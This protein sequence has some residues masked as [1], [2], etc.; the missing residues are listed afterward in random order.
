MRE[1]LDVTRGHGKHRVVQASKKDALRF[2][3]EPEVLSVGIERTAFVKM[4]L[5]AVFVCAIENDGTE[6]PVVITKGDLKGVD[7]VCND[8]DD[9][10]G[11]PWY[12]ADQPRRWSDVL[13]AHRLPST[14]SVIRNSG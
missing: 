2:R 10:D 12:Q 1:R 4:W 9:C 14:A 5:N 8:C 11:T 13:E 7:A 3:S 6:S